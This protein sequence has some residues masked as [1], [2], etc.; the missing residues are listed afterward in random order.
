MPMSND[1]ND[2]SE[3]A[4]LQGGGDAFWKLH[5]VLYARRRS[6]G[7]NPYG[8]LAT[9]TGL[10]GRQLVEDMES[11]RVRQTVAEDIRLATGPR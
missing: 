3:A 11:E 2:A 7:E 8:E 10:D 5:G 6:L 4:R 1:T 9:A